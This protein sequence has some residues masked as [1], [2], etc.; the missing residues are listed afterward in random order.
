MIYVKSNSF[1]RISFDFR[2]RCTTA[3]PLV[4][5]KIKGNP[6]ETVTFHINH[7]IPRKTS[8]AQANSACYTQ[9][10]YFPGVC[11]RF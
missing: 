2:E 11:K 5:L 6:V 4:T 8:L 9:Q 10:T 7:E 1:Q 3:V